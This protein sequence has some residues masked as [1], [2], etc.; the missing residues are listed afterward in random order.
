MATQ[1]R[2]KADAIIPFWRDSVMLGAFLQ[3]LFAVAIDLSPDWADRIIAAVWIALT[4][5]GLIVARQASGRVGL[6][7]SPQ[8]VRK[9]RSA[10]DGLDGLD[11]LDDL[12]DLT[13]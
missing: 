1:R 3:P 11:G 12:T 8:F 2:R 4:S 10:L 5:A 9:T 13:T 6:S 7:A